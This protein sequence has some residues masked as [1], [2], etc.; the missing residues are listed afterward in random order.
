MRTAWKRGVDWLE[1]R[2]EVFPGAPAAA[3]LRPWVWEPLDDYLGDGNQWLHHEQHGDPDDE[4]RG[5]TSAA[6]VQ[7][8]DKLSEWLPLM[9]VVLREAWPD[10]FTDS[11]DGWV[12]SRLA[13]VPDDAEEQ[14]I[15]L[16]RL[17]E[18]VIE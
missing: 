1:M 10:I 17:P 16:S 18:V 9:A 14:R 13:E 3:W 5:N 8:M 6:A 2:G 15:I 7:E 12:L 11:G 4:G